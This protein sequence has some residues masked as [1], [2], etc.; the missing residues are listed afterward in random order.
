MAVCRQMAAV[1]GPSQSSLKSLLH[2]ITGIEPVIAL[3]AE[4]DAFADNW[5]TQPV[6]TA[7]EAFLSARTTPGGTT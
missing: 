2:R 5:S 4:L 1:S 3:Q 7:L 6:S